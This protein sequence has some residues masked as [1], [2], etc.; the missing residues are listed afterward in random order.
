MSESRWRNVANQV[1]AR[2]VSENPGLPE[3]ELR[4][5]LSAAY[6]FVM[7]K[8]HPYKIWLSA[9]NEH[10]EPTPPRQHKPQLAPVNESQL[11]LGV[12]APDEGTP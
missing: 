10:F 7:R 11:S 8:Y 3:M 9:V 5:K 12:D 6:P 4:K 1:I 2:V